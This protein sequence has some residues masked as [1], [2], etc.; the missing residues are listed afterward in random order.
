VAA[1]A[2]QR[3]DTLA[4]DVLEHIGAIHAAVDKQRSGVADMF[5][6]VRST[7]QGCRAI[8]DE[9]EAMTGSTFALSELTE[10]T[11]LHFAVLDT[12]SV[13]HRALALGRELASQSGALLERVVDEGRAS[14][15]DVLAFDYREIRGEDIRSLA[16]LFDVAR[17]P[18]EGFDPPKYHTRYDA[19]VDVPLMA[20]MDAIKAREPALIFALAI[21]LN[22]YGPIHNRE[23][24][25]DWTGIRE[26]DLV[27]NRIK[28]FFT[29]QHVL[30]RGARVGLGQAAKLPDRATREEFLAAGC[31]LTERPGDRER[32]LVQT[33]AR[34]TGA[35]VTAI[36]VPIF[37]K[38]ERWGAALLGWNVD[39]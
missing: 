28:R 37:V 27:G 34:D 36:T 15:A 4:N 24:C 11:F 30:V 8:G 9:T 38:G 21:D 29:D 16:H 14:L 2:M 25:K 1:D 32:F 5:Q 20:A 12:G 33:Y 7:A 26:K 17:V 31:D 19:V 3:L 39:Q 6:G 22:S 35:I 10:E 18:R 13:F 23:Y